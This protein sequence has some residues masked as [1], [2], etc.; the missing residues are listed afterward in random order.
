MAYAQSRVSSAPQNAPSV[1]NET[2]NDWVVLCSAGTQGRMCVITQQQRKKDTNQLVLAVEFN[3]IGADGI[4]GSMILPFGLKLADGVTLQIDDGAVSRPNPFVTCMPAGCVVSLGF[5]AAAV[6][7]LRSGTAVKLVAK[8]HDGGQ[9]VL[10][11][12]SLKGF[13]T[14]LDRALD[15]AKS[16]I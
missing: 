16:P 10:L 9:N 1:I 15:L 2:Y 7:Q 4:K 8:A 11:N 13:S 3:E 12:V 5:D 6:T 14:A